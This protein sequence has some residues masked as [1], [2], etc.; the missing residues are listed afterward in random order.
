MK[1]AGKAMTGS[2]FD[3]AGMK[4]EGKGLLYRQQVI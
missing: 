3:P 2:G 4:G 1:A